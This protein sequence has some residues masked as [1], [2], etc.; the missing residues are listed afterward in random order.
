VI[1]RALVHDL[2]DRSR[3]S[4][5]RG[6]V[7]FVRLPGQLAGADVALVDLSRVDLALVPSVTRCLGFA[8]HLDRTT[9]EAARAIGIEAMPRS[10]FFRRLPL[11]L[12]E[13][14]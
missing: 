12:G 3:I 10:E 5:V 14:G 9:I 7:E 1:V 11:L 4:A 8:S 13:A 6:D 2:M